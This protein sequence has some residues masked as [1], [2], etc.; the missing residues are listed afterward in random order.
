MRHWLLPEH[1]ADI[2]PPDATYLETAKTT[3]LELF[4]TYGYDLVCP[5]LMEYTDSLLSEVDPALARKTFR[6]D[7]R[8]SGRQLGLRADITPQVARIDAHLLSRREGATRLCYCGSVLHAMPDSLFSSREPLQIGA[9]FYG[10]TDL[11]A[12]LEIIDLML[13]SLHALGVPNLVL[14]VGHMGVFYALTEAA[15]LSQ[16][17]IQTLLPLLQAKDLPSLT[18]LVAEFNEPFRRSFL[19]LPKLFG[20]EAL[21]RA[22]ECLPMSL[23]LAQA[24]DELE[25]VERALNA[26]HVQ[27]DYDLTELRGTHYHTGLIFAAY[28]QG[29]SSEL[30]RGGRYDN[31]GEKFGRARPATGFSLDLRNL[32]RLFP[33]QKMPSK[34]CAAK[35]FALEEAEFLNTLRE[36]GEVVVV[37]YLGEGA[38]ALG[39]DRV[40][41]KDSNGQIVVSM[42]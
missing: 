21:I 14:T 13:K 27:I 38:A 34:I 35:Q 18:E 19:E 7:D 28:A 40:I 3:V 39:C 10:C 30:A 31:V 22:R 25:Q 4:R 32:L 33:H 1:I 23:K 5:P 42:I 29:W 41:L 6:L 2:L 9:E 12:D 20:K 37:D 26:Q 17:Q 16:A 36:Q 8:L 24:L 15:Q 11:A